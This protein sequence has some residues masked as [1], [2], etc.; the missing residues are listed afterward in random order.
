MDKFKVREKF[1]DFFNRLPHVNYDAVHLLHDSAFHDLKTMLVPSQD[2]VNFA[3]GIADLIFKVLQNNNNEFA[4][5]RTRLFKSIEKN[6]VIKNEFHLDLIIYV[7]NINLL[8]EMFWNI[9]FKYWSRKK[10]YIMQLIKKI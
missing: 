6:T 3:R 8:S 10:R 2:E 9:L 1:D 7:N 5:D 4:I